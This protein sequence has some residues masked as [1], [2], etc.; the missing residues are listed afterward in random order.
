MPLIKG[1]FSNSILG[2]TIT[3]IH[4][5]QIFHSFVENYLA[6]FIEEYSP[7]VAC[8]HQVSGI[9][10]V[11]PEPDYTNVD[12]ELFVHQWRKMALA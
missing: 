2:V 3:A 1:G 6:C 5:C 10:S 7:T 11:S 4:H 8:D 9:F 12:L